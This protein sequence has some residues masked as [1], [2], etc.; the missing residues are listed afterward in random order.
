MRF[1]LIPTL[2]LVGLSACNT[3]STSPLPTTP[4]S[5]SANPIGRGAANS[6]AP[7]NY[8]SLSDTEFRVPASLNDS[9]LG[10]TGTWSSSELDLWGFESVHA[11]TAFQTLTAP[12]HPLVVAVIDT[13]LDYDAPDLAGKMWTNDGERGGGKESNGI[14]DDND[15]YIDDFMGWNWVQNNNHPVDDAGH[16]THVSGTIA[17][18]G[19]NARGIV[20]IAPW[21]KIMPLK[22]CDSAG[23]CYTDDVRS[24]ISYAISHGAKVINISLGAKSDTANDIAFND[25]IAQAEAAGVTV[26]TSAGNDS[27]D[28][29]QMAPANATF[30]IAVA[31]NANQ[32]RLCSSFSNYGWKIDISAPGCG[33]DGRLDVPGILSLASHKCGANG[34]MNCCTRGAVGSDYCLLWGT[35]M[36]SPH[37]SGLAALALTASPTATPLMVRQAL[38][39]AVGLPS[40][41]NTGAK[42]YVQG[43]GRADA[44]TIAREAVNAPGVKITAPRFDTIANT[45]NIEIRIET[46]AVSAKYVLKYISI[47]SSTTR[48]DMTAGVAIQ[49]QN[50]IPSATA[51]TET[52][53][54][55]PPSPGKYAVI[56]EV[57]P[58]GAA[59]STSDYFDMITL[60]R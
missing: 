41:M 50:F 31:A 32:G 30:A 27:T 22:V 49:S 57:T 10:T 53:P 36:A 59:P 7:I 14:D 54:W 15:G 33:F 38:L 16:G 46:R 42:D 58:G 11:R 8:T 20:G 52:I 3:D 19:G 55:M 24:A 29:I 56:L 39:H 2:Y 5:T 43:Y 47:D 17:A 35:S 23:R 21:V 6:P 51:Y 34:Q 13:G 4:P 28:V 40:G 60:S 48:L 45:H 25:A 1:I 44:A 26:V 18:T 12:A 37:V 9:F